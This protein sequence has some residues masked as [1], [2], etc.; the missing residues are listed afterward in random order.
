M[1]TAKKRY[2]AIGLMSGTSLDGVDA[3][4]LESDGENIYNYFGGYYLP[5]ER[6][7]WEELKFIITQPSSEE[8]EFRKR[9]SERDLT[10]LHY[11]I[12][13]KIKNRLKLDKI[14]LIG[15]H[16]Q[17]IKHDPD[18]GYTEQIGD[19]NL[20]ARLSGIDVINNFR[21]ND[22][23][24]GGQGAPLVPIF[25]QA[26]SNKDS[27]EVFLN[28]G[29]VANIC[30][31]GKDQYVAGNN[32]ISFDIGPGNAPMNDLVNKKLN[33]LYDDKGIIASTG[34]PDTDIVTEFLKQ[35]FF[36]QKP[37]KSL[38][39]NRFNYDKI[40]NLALPDALATI[41]YIIAHSLQ[42]AFSFL[43]VG[44]RKIKA[45]GGGLHNKNLIKI[46]EEVCSI[47]VEPI[48]LLTEANGEIAHT[49]IGDF[50]E[51]YAFA[52][53]SIRSFLKL[54]ISFPGTTGTKQPRLGGVFCPAS[55]F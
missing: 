20:L 52:F 42:K 2:T 23:M 24:H 36:E 50:I 31:C 22:V 11:E 49:D 21:S 53:L 32:L 15:F 26:L 4:V 7:I 37:P 40:E 5:Y 6:K 29:G 28:I 43:P 51:A 45:S 44:C 48:R 39:R 34:K 16:G 47:K 3:A 55:A 38:D 9:V 41:S 27:A 14:D 35:D 25:L 8:I 17:T 1:E 19:G 33:I 18:I 46:I 12:V 10:L 54:P 13:K 30:Y